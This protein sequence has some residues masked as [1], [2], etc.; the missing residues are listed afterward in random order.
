MGTLPALCY[1]LHL[2]NTIGCSIQ[3]GVTCLS[4]DSHSDSGAVWTGILPGGA[5]A[6]VLIIGDTLVVCVT[7]SSDS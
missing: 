6:G 2:G 5:N 3:W 1:S 7:T 4:T